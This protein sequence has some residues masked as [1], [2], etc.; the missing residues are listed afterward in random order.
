MSKKSKSP[1]LLETLASIKKIEISRQDLIVKEAKDHVLQH[2]NY[3][4]EQIKINFDDLVHEI[5]GKTYSLYLEKEREFGK[6]VL[7]LLVEKI[8]NDGVA[9]F[10][11]FEEK[12]GDYFNDLDAFYMSLAQ[13]RKSRAGK[14]FEN[15][16]KFL[17]SS[18]K[19]PFDVQQVINGKPDFLLPSRRHYDQQAMDCIIF[20][21]KRTLRERWRQIVTEGTRGLGFYLAT[22]DEKISQNQLDEMNEHR[23]YLVCPKEIKNNR[24]ANCRNVLTFSRFFEDHLDPAMTRWK[25]NGII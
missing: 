23:I 14:A 2:H 5:Q 9:S 13:S 17:F 21:A 22:V 11:T 3:S 1:S 18:L 16:I 25:K 24:Y 8:K 20:T 4:L 7:R 19:Y 10:E 15:I 12:I 6:K